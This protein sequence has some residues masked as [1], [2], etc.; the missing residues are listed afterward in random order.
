M[1]YWRFYIALNHPNKQ[2][3]RNSHTSI[4]DFFGKFG[5]RVLI[6]QTRKVVRV[7]YLLC[8]TIQ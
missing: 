1:Q 8:G 6:E 7:K 3:I 5:F 4:L 2:S